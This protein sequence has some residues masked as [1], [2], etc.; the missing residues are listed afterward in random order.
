MSRT[1]QTTLAI[2]RAAKQE[3]P[4]AYMA[5][6]CRELELKAA[7]LADE[8]RAILE[9]ARVEKAPLREQEI[10]SIKRALSE[11]EA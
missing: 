8:L 9:W 5:T 4:A 7:A 10:A 2:R 6:V 11:Y 3:R 1:P